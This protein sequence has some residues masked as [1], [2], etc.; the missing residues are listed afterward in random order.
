MKPQRSNWYYKRL[1]NVLFGRTIA[2]LYNHNLQRLTE[3]LQVLSGLV[4]LAFV[5]IVFTLVASVSF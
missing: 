1:N 3:G 4:I 5:V 2:R